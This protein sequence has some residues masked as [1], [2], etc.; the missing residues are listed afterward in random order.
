MSKDTLDRVVQGRLGLKVQR[1][2]NIP[3]Q[4]SYSVGE[5]VS[6]MMLLAWHLYPDDFAALA[7]AILSH[8][9]GE[10][11]IGDI[12]APTMRYVPGLR[13]AIG[14]LENMIQAEYGLFPEERL[15][16][17]L[18]AKLKACDRLE[19]LLWALEQT[20][21]GNHY[22]QG[23][24]EEL[25]LYLGSEPEKTLPGPAFLFYQRL[26]TGRD[27]FPRQAGVVRAIVEKAGA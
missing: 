2:H 15:P 6:G 4:G 18:H 9:I 5:H 23:C 7:P 1:C 27:I 22:A 16:L 25:M 20:G 14:H 17:D 10:G 11:W 21:T 19:L 3:H 24:I 12:P 8:D 26:M 13:E